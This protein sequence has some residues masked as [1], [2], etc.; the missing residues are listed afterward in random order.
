M[1]VPWRGVGKTHLLGWTREQVQQAGGYFFLVKIESQENFWDEVVGAYVDRLQPHN[2][3]S[4]NQLEALLADLTRRAGVGGALRDAVMGQVPPTPADLNQFLVTLRQLD[5]SVGMT[6][7]DTARA[8]VLLASPEPEHQ[9]IGYYFLTNGDV[10]VDVRRSWG[11]R[12]RPK[13]RWFMISEL[14]NLLALSGPAVLAVDQIDALIDEIGKNPDEENPASERQV[15]QIASGL[16]SLRDATH[17][18]LTIL[19][20][21]PE[22]WNYIENNAVDTVTDRFRQTVPLQNLPNPGIAATM[23]AK[24]F[25]IEFASVGFEP[26]YPTWPIRESAFKEARRYTARQ[27][28][29]R[30]EDHVNR[31]LRERTVFELE[32]LDEMADGRAGSGHA[33]ESSQAV[34][35]L[36]GQAHLAQL[37]AQFAELRAQTDV[38]A[39][40]DPKAEDAVVPD[41]LAAGLEAWIRERGD[42]RYEFTQDPP[43]SRKPALHACLML[44]V[45]E[46]TE[47]QHKWAF[48]AISA[49]NAKAFLNRLRTVVSR[50]GLDEGDPSKQLFVL[51]N[52][53][54]PSGPT[55]DREKAEF[56]AKGGVAITVSGDDLTIFAALGKMLASR[57]PSLNAWLMARQPAHNTALLSRTLRSASAHRK[58]DGQP[59]SQAAPEPP[60]V[61]PGW[62]PARSSA[63]GRTSQRAGH[64]HRNRD[65]GAGIRLVGSRVTPSACGNFRGQRIRKNRAAAAHRR[66]MRSARGIVDR[67]RSQQRPGPA[68]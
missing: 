66:G 67:P 7:Q 64:S 23:I 11:I 56:E 62:T 44:T 9:D 19:S 41:L 50:S 25:A 29:R 53:R 15:T 51:R 20:C 49:D 57:H 31:S 5:R 42:D 34:I 24:R 30:I 48:R 10:D 47:R 40:F 18:T 65:D 8:L 1:P 61:T 45:D 28:L 13:R 17:R 6:C 39:A 55:S 32:S 16:M 14:S 68:G 22:S 35:A 58:L 36:T 37:D 43:P 2:D 26:P 33:V 63:P 38:S 21:L 3:G 59:A 27:L 60:G 4:R 12:S 54:W 52:T 46:R